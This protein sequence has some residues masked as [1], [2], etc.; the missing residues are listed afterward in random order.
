MAL[1]G[2]LLGHY[3]L[4]RLIGSGGMG[5]IYVA[6]DV[7]MPRKVAVKIIR[8]EK[9]PYADTTIKQEAERLFQREMQAIALLDHPHILPVFDYGTEQVDGAE[10][11][12]LVMPYRPEGSLLD[13]L[14]KRGRNTL[15]APHEVIHF[16]L[17]AADALQHAHERHIVHQDI[18]PSNFLIRI[19]NSEA[20]LPDLLLADFGI[21]KVINANSSSQSVRGTPSYMSPEQWEGRPVPAS[22]QYSLAVM[23]FQL[24]TGQLPFRGGPGQV[25]H[26]HFNAQ[27]PVPSTLN[28]HLSPAI[29]AV[30]LRAL[31]KRP[32]E[33]FPSIFQFAQAFQRALSPEHMSQPGLISQGQ[34]LQADARPVAVTSEQAM[35]TFRDATRSNGNSYSRQQEPGTSL[36]AQQ[37][38]PLSP[39]RLPT[40]EYAMVGSVQA[41]PVENKVQPS[42]RLSRVQ[43][44]LLSVV[45]ALVILG[46]SGVFLVYRAN[47]P[48]STVK[49][50]TKKN[51]SSL[52]THQVTA[53]AQVEKTVTAQVKA[54]ADAQDIA[55]DPYLSGKGTLL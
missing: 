50:S 37:Q 42:S 22:D 45:I 39:L 12:Y 32:E 43:K 5:E 27:P 48:A 3:Q 11:T 25:M 46:G 17:Q 8:G 23:A 35:T 53:T 6:D 31:A 51:T 49:T 28:P 13:Q 26:Q 36:P 18:K 47:S 14:V 24:L 29:D 41:M 2:R 38:I 34:F 33:R 10:L 15:L 20:Y 30:L 21:A 19:R 54:T 55:N 16:L 9:D 1:E 4:Q 52:A 44:I 40:K 7:H